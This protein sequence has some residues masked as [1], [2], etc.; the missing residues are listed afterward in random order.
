MDGPKSGA[1]ISILDWVPT[2]DHAVIPHIDPHM[3]RS[4]CVI[5]SLKKD[6]VSRFCF[7]RRYIS[8]ALPQP[9]RRCPSHI[10]SVSAMIDHPA[11]KP[12]TVKTGRRR[13]P[14]PHIGID[15]F[16]KSQLK[17]LQQKTYNRYVYTYNIRI[18]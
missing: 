18:L 12:G 3:A 16:F 2:V 6:Q 11:H 10:P 7:G 15:K 14:A 1:G 13:S 5:S 9:L 8:A 4:G 17:K